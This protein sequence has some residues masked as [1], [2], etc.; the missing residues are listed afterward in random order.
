ML[1]S[2][3]AR[4]L[5]EAGKRFLVI[6]GFRFDMRRYPVLMEANAIRGGDS[7]FSQQPFR[8]LRQTVFPPA[9]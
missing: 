9:K 4:V 2:L 7:G 5:D 1:E 8:D 6:A 3:P